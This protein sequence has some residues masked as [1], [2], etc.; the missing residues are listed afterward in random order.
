MSESLNI[1]IKYTNL[2]LWRW[3]QLESSLEGWSQCSGV[4][5][6]LLNAQSHIRYFVLLNS[7]RVINPPD[8]SLFSFK[9]H[10]S[11]S[12]CKKGMHHFKTAL[13]IASLNG[14]LHREIKQLSP[15]QQPVQLPSGVN[16][17]P[18]H[19]LNPSLPVR[20]RTHYSASHW[21]PDWPGN[22]SRG[23]IKTPVTDVSK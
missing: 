3:E 6:G 13:N 18:I 2:I 9:G 20:R 19:Y 22:T 5:H 4:R 17:Y 16:R 7:V 21:S 8:K 1:N 14:S 12:I 11:E 10:P 23:R 15:R